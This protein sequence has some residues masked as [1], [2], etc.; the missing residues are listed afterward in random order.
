MP[1]ARG[2][3]QMC[4][5]L[6]SMSEGG[7]DPAFLPFWGQSQPL[8]FGLNINLRIGVA[9]VVPEELWFFGSKFREVFVT[10]GISNAS[11]RGSHLFLRS[12][13]NLGHASIFFRCSCI[14]GGHDGPK[15]WAVTK[16]VKSGSVAQ[17]KSS[18]FLSDPDPSSV[19]DLSTDVDWDNEHLASP[20][21][22]PPAI[23]LLDLWPQLQTVWRQRLRVQILSTATTTTATHLLHSPRATT[24]DC[25]PQPRQES[26]VSWDFLAGGQSSQSLPIGFFRPHFSLRLIWEMSSGEIY[27]RVKGNEWAPRPISAKTAPVSTNR[28][29]NFGYRAILLFC[30]KHVWWKK[31]RKSGWRLDSVFSTPINTPQLQPSL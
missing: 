28:A 17:K 24:L 5:C 2:L 11:V 29:V 20:S 19:G 10:W 13:T 18:D 27:G 8:P 16:R 25:I 31:G 4:P 9:A 12:V 23:H 1:G 22:D 3:C 6:M 30:Q 21:N 14:T 15:I 26:C 7:S